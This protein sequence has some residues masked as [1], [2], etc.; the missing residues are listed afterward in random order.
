MLNLGFIGFASPWLLVALAALPVLWWLL[1]VT[2]PAP[3]EVVFPP[4]RL[5]LGLLPKEETPA[6]TPWWLLLLRLLV[7]ALVILALAQPILNPEARLVARGP[8]LLVLDDGWAGASD[9]SRKIDAAL[10]AI[11]QAE[12][13]GRPVA[14]LGT[15]APASGEPMRLTRLR[16]AGEVRP[17]VQAWQPK[18]WPVDRA[19]ALRAIGELKF[20]TAGEVVWISDGIDTGERSE[21]YTLAERLQWLGGL[22]VIESPRL[23]RALLPPVVDAGG[24]KLRVLRTPSNEPETVNILASADQGRVMTRQPA[25]FEADAGSAE[26]ILDLPLELRNRLVRLDIEGAGTAGSTVLLDERWRRRPVGLVSGSAEESRQPLL[27]DLYYIDRALAPFNEVRS[28]RIAELLER[29]IALI[30]LADIGQVVGNE[31]RLLEDWIEKGGVLVR[32]AGPR[33][34]ETTDT[35]LP[36]RVRA[37][38]GRLLGGTMSWSQPAR[39][40]AFPNGS[41]FFGLEVP[42]DVTVTRQVLAEPE[43]DLNEKTWARLEDG[44]PL[45]TAERRGRGWLVLFHTTSNTQWS[46]LAISGMFV[47]MLRRTADLAQGVTATGSREQLPPL[48]LLDGLGRLGRPG[49]AAQALDA[50]NI[51]G[52]AVGPR[53]PPGFYG[54]EDARRAFNLTTGIAELRRIAGWPSGV[55]ITGLDGGRVRDL[56]PPLLTA[57]IILALIDLIIA[58]AMRGLFRRARLVGAAGA[59]LLLVAGTTAPNDATAQSQPQAAVPRNA[60]ELALRAATEMRLAFVITGNSEIDNTSRSGLSGLSEVLFRR[61]SIEAAPPFGAD[62]ERDE[63]AVFPFLYWPMSPTQP[64]VSAAAL[65]RIDQFMKTG[66]LILFDTRDQGNFTI[67]TG[68]VGPGTQKLR[69]LLA[70]LDIPPLAPVP[71]DHV[72][73]KAFYLMQDFPGRYAGGQVWVERNPGGAKDG[74]TSVVIGGGDWAAAWATDQNGRPVF[75]LI[76]G[77]PTQR[78]MAYRFGVNLVMYTLT[79]NYKADQV[80]VPAL[81]ERLGQ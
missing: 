9:W 60:E 21:A 68:Q 49:P 1:R 57:A 18:P 11:D 7:A 5:L 43:V 22:R 16:P 71:K 81:L 19:A 35:L 30:A 26:I 54:Q 59:L 56:M 36:V 39:F 3:R 42:D 34:A 33:L 78:E 48:S 10:G 62:L 64:E 47:D 14:V 58:F 72:L 63:I 75:P 40:A 79:G 67:G 12:S 77:T 37:G 52:T 24:M 20:E 65:A 53:H 45:V 73:T 25:R 55:Q 29:E 51:A 74:V 66:G 69:Q 76:P 70:K 44:T 80:H 61:T 27:S 28:G 41:P 38:G 4:L 23:A 50:A 15:A 2:P 13:D 46:N 6:H 31:K 17:L 8:L 32:F